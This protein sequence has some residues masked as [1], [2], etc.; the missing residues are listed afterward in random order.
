MPRVV[1]VLAIVCLAI[2]FLALVPSEIGQMDVIG[3]GDPA[4]WRFVSGRA[5]TRTEFIAVVATCEDGA[6]RRLHGR[7]LDACLADLG[8]RRLR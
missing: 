5:P 6:I 1:F 4:Q 2:A 3:I 8:L 7:P